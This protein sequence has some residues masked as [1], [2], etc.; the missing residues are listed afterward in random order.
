MG[1]SGGEQSA[2]PRN[3]FVGRVR[4][5]AELVSACEAGADTDAHLFLIYG[6]PGIGKTRLADELASRVKARG[7][8]VL[9]GRCWE[10]ECAP[11][12]WPWIQVIRG[13]LGT[14][15]PQRRIN[16]AVDSEIGADI[17]HDVSQI[18]PDLRPAPTTLSPAVTDK[19][20]PSEARFRLFDAVTNF[21]KIG[22]RSHPMV[23][24]LD[25]LHD[26][27]EAS[28]GLLRFMA[29][30]LKG[31]AIML[32]GTYRDMEVRRSPGLSKMIGE[33][34]REARSIPV[35]GLSESE[36]TKFVEFRAGQRPDDELIAKLCAATNGNPLFVDGIVR[37]LIAEGAIGLAGAP[38]RPFKI[39]G[40]IRGAI[41]N[42][43]DGLSLESNSIL[44]TAAAIG[45]EFD[46]NL[47]QSVANVSTDE[48]H[49]LLDETTHAGIVTALGHGRYRFSHAL[50]R[51]AVY[52]ELD[53]NSRIRIHGKIANRIEQIYQDDEAPHLAELAHHF[54]EANVT[55]KAIDYLVRAGRAANSV[56]AYTDAMAHW[57]A[58]FELMEEHGADVHKRA[59]VAELLGDVAFEIDHAKSAKYGE[60]AIAFYESI[61]CFD[62]A[63]KTHIVL[64]KIFTM[65][66]HAQFNGALAEEHFRRAKSVLTNGPETISLARLYRQIA[67]H[68]YLKMDL[69][70]SASAARRAMEIS[71][72]LG[73]KAAWSD[74][75]QSYAQSL[76]GSGQLEKGFVLLE[77]AFEAAV[78]ANHSGFGVAWGAGSYTR[79]LGDPKGARGWFERELFRPIIA[80]APYRHQFLSYLSDL[81]YL[82]EG[83]LGEARRRLGS[84]DWGIRFWVGGEW[85]AIAA[86]T[87]KAAEASQRRGDRLARSD[88]SI[89][90]G[91]NYLLLGK[92]A[93]A[94]A[95]LR[96]GLDNGDRAPLALQE[97]RARPMLARVYIA[98]NRLDA[99]ADQVARCRQIMAAGENWRG[100]AGDTARSEAIVAAASGSYA[101]AD[102]RFESALAI[103]QMYRSALE[104]AVTLISWGSALGAA[105][106]RMRAE[107]KFNAAL[108][109]YR[110]CGVG[111]RMIESVVADKMRA[112]RTHPTRTNASSPSQTQQ[113]ESKPIGAFRKEGEFWTISYDA[114]T[115]R[116]KD[117]KGLRYIAYLLARPGQR[118]HVY[119]LIEAVEGS[120]ANGKKR[121]DAESE[122]LEI[123]RE[124][125]APGPAIDARARSEYRIRLRD[126]QAELDEADRANDLGQSQRIR[127]EIEMVGHE[128]TGSS[129]L[130]GR[131]RAASGSSERARGLVGKN[132]RSMVEKIRHQH[133][134]LGRHLA[135]AIRTGY[136]CAYQSD[137]DRPISWQI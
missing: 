133:P 130:G 43:L 85:E 31:A 22:A 80:R 49:R 115:F 5:L 135:G 2:S 18:I 76:V 106:D 90:L 92:Y 112:L 74:A 96:S 109:I 101:I 107:E 128:L 27:D 97:M 1:E 15:E 89:S 82:D 63:A 4:E 125:D 110:L 56:F 44:A 58:A 55:E 62:K 30:E 17:I 33:L 123:V 77:Q 37:A 93:S 66:H 122:D 75:A 14:L 59:E 78:Q 70:Q 117:A 127:A 129:G 52:E 7:R 95:H 26:A 12:Y 21:L 57:E 10:G 20:D 108:E 32:V 118:I 47:C 69:S 24:V 136:F 67:V 38:D 116:L 126:L 99:A 98:M 121:V 29:R 48:A 60:A 25:D 113:A 86:L 79:C 65:S 94:E 61:G 64:G 119:D 16:L 71:D 120:A 91:G 102:E 72:R 105:G 103:H 42:R 111:P 23:I 68:E 6:E 51:E 35:G 50:I 53:T 134:A 41:R 39:P 137:P 114:T 9:W 124:I 45:N 13:F 28:L 40:G 34:G 100:L 104:E 11:A 132:I 46:F 19:L 81:T 54:R 131:A 88:S 36:V 8:L 83:Q 84:E 3:A 73:H 87:E